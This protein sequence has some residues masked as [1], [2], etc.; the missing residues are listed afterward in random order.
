MIQHVDK[1]LYVVIMLKR[2]LALHLCHCSF[3]LCEA[4][5]DVGCATP[6]THAKGF[7]SCSH[8]TWEWLAKWFSNL[9]VVWHWFDVVMLDSGGWWSMHF[10][11]A[12]L[13]KVPSFLPYISFPLVSHTSFLRIAFVDVPSC[14][15]T[16]HVLHIYAHAAMPH[17]QQ[18]VI[19]SIGTSVQFPALLWL[20]H[21]CFQS[22]HFPWMFFGC[23]PKL[24]DRDYPF[25]KKTYML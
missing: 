3:S 16:Y 20:A 12:A 14:L 1:Q 25:L 17:I 9:E 23:F 21:F 4:H 19:H 7:E 6:S 24:L 2:L 10:A 5:A 13:V 18:P 15:F 11:V 22:F 8:L